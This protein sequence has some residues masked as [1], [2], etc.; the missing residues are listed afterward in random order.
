MVLFF[1]YQ[2][3][4]NIEL[5]TKI[6]NNFEIND[7]HIIIQKYDEENNILEISDNLINNNT[8]LYGKLVNFNNMK[9]EDIIQKI[10]KINEC[11]FKNKYKNYTLDTIW[12]NKINGGVYKANIIY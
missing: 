12:V 6:S 11:K 7:G 8:I 1:F 2:K 9:I 5:L 10:S 3:L 4:T